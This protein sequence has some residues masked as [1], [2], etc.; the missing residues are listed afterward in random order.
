VTVDTPA[1]RAVRDR[2]L[3]LA[4]PG[5]LVIVR[6]AEEPRQAPAPVE[7]RVATLRE[8]LKQGGQI[9]SCSWSSWEEFHQHWENGSLAD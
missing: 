6:P 5:G 4:V 2:L 8:R 3:A 7:G 9:A 1:H